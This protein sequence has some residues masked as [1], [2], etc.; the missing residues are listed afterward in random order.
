MARYQNVDEQMAALNIEDEENESLIFEGDIEENVNRYELCL[1]GRFLTEKNLNVRAMKSKM[2]NIWKPTMGINIRELE[3]ALSSVPNGEDPVKVPL[4]HLSFWIQIYDLPSGFINESVGRQ[5]GNFFGEFLQYDEK[6]DASIW[7]EFMRLKIRIDVRKPLKRKK[8]ITRKNKTEVVV[9]SKYERLGEF[10][11]S[12]GLVTH[13]ERFCRRFIDKRGEQGAKDWGNWLKAPPRRMARTVKSKWPREDGDDSWESRIGRENSKAKFQENSSSNSDLVS[14]EGRNNR[15]LIIL[16]ADNKDSSS[17]KFV[18]TNFV[19]GIS[20]SNPL[21]GPV[22]EEMSGLQSEERKR[23]RVG[24]D[25]LSITNT[26][27][28]NNPGYCIHH[29]YFELEL[30]RDRSTLEDSLPIRRYTSTA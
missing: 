27:E 23:K 12:C 6:N 22:D 3:P 8:K 28:A 7:R 18:S 25:N 1:V 4:W 21:F 29:E 10:C 19:G 24:S 5:L 16:S 15:N 13:T 17:R 30:S 14:N 26:E 9:S 2:A 20:F 11:F